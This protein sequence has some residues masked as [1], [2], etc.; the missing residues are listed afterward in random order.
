MDN[1][2][3]YIVSD[4]GKF[5]DLPFFVKS[6]KFKEASK[7]PEIEKD[8]AFIVDNETK[9]SDIESIIKKSGGRL[10]DNVEIFDIYNNIEEGKKSMAYNLIF[11]D[12]TRTLSDDE[13]MEV[14]NKIINDV[15]S[16][17]NAKLRD[18]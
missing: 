14:F 3:G 5:N 4:N 10:L 8:V 17:L 6:I 15:T 2:L 1:Y 7:Y 11:K 18:K 16:K 12:P 9:N 13:V